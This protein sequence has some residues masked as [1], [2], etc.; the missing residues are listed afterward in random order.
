[1]A[2]IICLTAFLCLQFTYIHACLNTYQYKI[3]PIGLE[4][5]KLLTIDVEIL[6]T[7]PREG[8]RKLKLDLEEPNEVMEMWIMYTYVVTY[9]ASQ[10]VL[11][12]SPLDTVF[13]IGEIYKEKLLEAYQSAYNK[14]LK[15]YPNLDLLRPA[16]ISFCDYQKSCNLISVSYHEKENSDSLTFEDQQYS[17][18]IFQDTSYLPLKNGENYPN[19]SHLYTNSVRTYKTGTKTFIFAHLATGHEIGMGWMT[20]DPNK[21]RIPG[22]G[23]VILTKEHSPDFEFNDLAKAVYQEPLLHHGFGF[24]IFIV[25]E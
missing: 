25:K 4:G 10:K 21:K 1:M 20:N 14:I 6:R 5:D 17:I 22:G 23:P 18:D 2:K 19:S 8:I 7:S 12:L 3:F 16:Y 11:Q 15:Q 13:T 24:D 9:D